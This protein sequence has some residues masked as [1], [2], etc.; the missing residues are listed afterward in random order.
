MLDHLKPPLPQF[1]RTEQTCYGCPSQWDAWDADG[2]QYYL[3]F[4]WGVGTLSL[5]GRMVDGEMQHLERGEQ[6]VSFQAGDPYSGIISLD[7][8]LDRAR[9]ALNEEN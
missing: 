6:I 5:R 4:R 9:A 8:F 3:R 7:E 1:T 2:N